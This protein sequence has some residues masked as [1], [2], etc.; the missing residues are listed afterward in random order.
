MSEFQSRLNDSNH[1][2]IMKDAD[3]VLLRAKHRNKN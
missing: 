1:L 2:T 3:L